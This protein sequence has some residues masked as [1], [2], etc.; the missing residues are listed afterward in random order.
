M[1]TPVR[2]YFDRTAGEFDAIH[3][4]GRGRG[5]LVDRVFRRG[6][7]QRFAYVL[8]AARTAQPPLAT[9]LDIGCGGGKYCVALAQAGLRATGIDFAPAMTGLATQRAQVAGVAEQ[10]TF[11]T[12][13]VMTLD[14]APADLVLA[15]GVFDYVADAAPL[16]ARLRALTAREGI[17]SFPRAGTWPGV[18]RRLW[19]LT[20]RCPVYYYTAADLR[21]LTD[22][23]TENVTIVESIRGDRLL[24]W[25][26]RA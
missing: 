16:L 19:L 9:L 15:I 2:D 25:R 4:R 18:L 11:H 26:Q 8:E 23:W 17:A 10:C 13:D 21:R 7:Q 14:L 24:H 20:R 5:T 22:G 1:N 12:G 6:M 3:E